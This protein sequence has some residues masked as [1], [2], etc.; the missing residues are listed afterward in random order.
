MYE[1][2]G[3]NISF[4][5]RLPGRQVAWLDRLTAQIESAVSA[6]GSDLERYTLDLGRRF[7]RGDRHPKEGEEDRDG[8]TRD[9]ESGEPA[10]IDAA[11]GE[12]RARG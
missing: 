8:T 11:E 3:S 7:Q 12:G 10:E 9:Q 2:S 4:C 6:F 1:K 5:V